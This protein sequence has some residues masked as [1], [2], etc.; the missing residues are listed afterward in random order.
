MKLAEAI[1]RKYSVD[2]T[3]FDDLYTEGIIG[4]MY[5]AKK[6]DPNRGYLFSTYARWWVSSRIADHLRKNRCVVQGRQRGW[7][8]INIEIENVMNMADGQPLADERVGDAQVKAF[9]WGLLRFCKN[10][11]ERTLLERRWLRGEHLT[12]A[13][14][15]EIYGMTGERVRQVEMSLFQRINQSVDIGKILGI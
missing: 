12:L 14:I 5:A 2:R 10:D 7:K 11:V 8:G 6:W 13:D 1:A 3:M 15:G 4:L 9:A